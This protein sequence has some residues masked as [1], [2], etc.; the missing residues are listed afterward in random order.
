MSDFNPAQTKITMVLM[1]RTWRQMFEQVIINQDQFSKIK[2]MLN[3]KTTA[4]VYLPNHRSHLDY[5]LLTYVHWF[6]NQQLPYV[7]GTEKF[8]HISFVTKI[9]RASGGFFIEREQLKKRVYK[10]I[11]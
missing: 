7:C 5:L 2:T 9:L 1:Q 6:Y 4:V 8:L 11:L 10:A 3:D